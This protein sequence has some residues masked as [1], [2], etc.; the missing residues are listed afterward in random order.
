MEVVALVSSSAGLQVFS[1]I[2][3]AAFVMKKSRN[4]INSCDQGHV[5]RGCQELGVLGPRLGQLAVCYVI[6]VMAGAPCEAWAW[7]DLLD[8]FR[9]TSIEVLSQ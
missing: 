3:F 6:I 8:V 2:D 1:P 7:L 4:S 9:L 5:S